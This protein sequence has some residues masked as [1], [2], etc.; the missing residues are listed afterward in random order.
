MTLIRE[1]RVCELSRM[2]ILTFITMKPDKVLC[3]EGILTGDKAILESVVAFGWV[4]IIQEA[5]FM[6]EG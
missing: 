4:W 1:S 2:E 3:F 6:S 5:I